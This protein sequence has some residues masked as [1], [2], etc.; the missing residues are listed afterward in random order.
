[1]TSFEVTAQRAMTIYRFGVANSAPGM[2]TMEVW[3]R[4]GGIGVVPPANMPLNNWTL[5]GSAAVDTTVAGAIVQVPVNVDRVMQTNETIGV[6]LIHTSNVGIKTRHFMNG[7]G[8]QP[9]WTNGDVTINHNSFSGNYMSS[10]TPRFNTSTYGGGSGVSAAYVTVW[11]DAGPTVTT[12]LSSLALPNAAAGSSG[13]TATYKAGGALLTADTTI[14]APAG[15]EVSFQPTTG[16]SPSLMIPTY[17]AYPPTDIY[18]RISDTASVG[19]LSGNIVHASPGA[20]SRTVSLSGTVIAMSVSQSGVD[21][22]ATTVGTPGVPVSYVLG[23]SSLTSNT[24]ITATGGFAVAT[25]AGGPFAAALTLTA[26]TY[27]QPIYVLLT[28]A[29]VGAQ[30]GTITNTSGPASLMVTVTGEVLPPYDLKVIRLGPDATADVDNDEPG[31]K[32][33]L[34]FKL[35]SFAA[36]WTVNAFTFTTAGAANAEWRR[37]CLSGSTRGPPGTQQGAV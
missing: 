27:N 3:I 25:S 1:M 28:G 12:S 16:F 23:G 21:A 20:P 13:A 8:V 5:V 22:G 6:V 2:S 7:A 36:A 4:P 15:V 11:Y 29:T 24:A 32:P 9:H 26:N 34:D 14:T 10:A 33:L 37:E 31:L 19:A 35:Q 18:V 30:A 17:P